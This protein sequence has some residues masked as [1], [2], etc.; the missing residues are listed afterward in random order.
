M[1]YSRP[2]QIGDRAP[3]FSLPNQSGDLVNIGDLIAKKPLVLYF[4]PKDD[5]PGCIAESCAFRDRYEVF[6]EIGAEVIGI[7]GD[8]SASHQQFASKY[9][10]PFTLLSDTENRIRE[11]YGVP[12]T[13][14]IL[15]G[16]VTY[17][18][19]RQGFVRH[20]YNSQLNFNAHVEESLKTLRRFQPI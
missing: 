5:T 19:D 16:R 12:A 6:R 17:V 15:P 18:V 10:L 4:Y 1:S 13:M 7:S 11:L 20:I 8:T 3:G 2:I 9:Q 14:F